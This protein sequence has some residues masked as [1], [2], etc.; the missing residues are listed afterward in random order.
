MS[1]ANTGAHQCAIE[2][3]FSRQAVGFAADRELHA[4]DVVAL[5]VEAARPQPHDA[6]IDF[7]CGTGSVA[8]ALAKRARRVVGLDATEAMLRQARDLASREGVG[9][10]EWRA[11]D[12]YRTPFAD[13]SFDVATCRFAFHHLEDPARAFAEMVRVAAPGARIVVC[14]SFASDDPQKA[15]AFNAMERFRDPSTVEHRTL[16][17]LRGLF[18]SAGLGAPVV[19]RFDVSY[20]ASDFVAKAFPLNGDGA[21]LLAMIESS[22]EGD[23]MDAGAHW[24]PQGVRFSFRAAALSAVKPLG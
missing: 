11:G 18:E 2:D 6:A 13:A 17:F 8:C 24:T 22:V 23:A 3:Q 16:P 4:D 15:A 21:R 7:A 19:R 10:V 14:D 9:N 20:F 12:V 5:V 1:P